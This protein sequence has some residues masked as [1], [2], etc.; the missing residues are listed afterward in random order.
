MNNYYMC[1][2]Q[3]N[4]LLYDSLPTLGLLDQHSV[5]VVTIYIHTYTC[6]CTCVIFRYS[7]VHVHTVPWFL[8]ATKSL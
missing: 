4:I 8:S 5:H 2:V 6:I 3:T 7:H 1:I